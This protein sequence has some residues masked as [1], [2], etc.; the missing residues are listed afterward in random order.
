ML[1]MFVMP[2]ATFTVLRASAG[3]AAASQAGALAIKV[4]AQASAAVSAAAE[5]QQAWPRLVFD[6]L[7]PLLPWL[8]AAW[9]L[10]VLALSLRLL[11][12]WRYVKYLRRHGT[13][14]VSGE[15]QQVLEG[16]LK[17]LRITKPISL[18]ESTVIKIPTV[19]GW[20]RPAIL[21]PTSALTGLSADQIKAII[22]HELAHIRRYDFLINLLQT[23]IE[24][25]LFYHPAVWW[26]SKRV[27]AERENCCDDVAVSVCGDALNYARA[28]TKLEQLRSVQPQLA[29]AATGGSLLGR[30]R[31]LVS[32]P[33]HR[34][35]PMSLW[36]AG[37]L[38][39]TI[40]FAAGAG[41]R[42]V[43]S[44]SSNYQPP[45][46]PQGSAEEQAAEGMKVLLQTLKGRNFEMK[47]EVVAALERIRSSGTIEPMLQALRD[48][49]E[50]T[51]EKVA[52]ALGNLR[53]RRAVEPLAA[54]LTSGDWRGQH[55]VAWA[56]GMIGDRRAVEPLV[57][58]LK[59]G[60]AD[61]RHGSAWALGKI[62]DK[63]AIEP[64][65]ALLKDEAA[66]VRH[67]AAWALGM[68][69]DP[70]AVDA[71]REAQNDKDSDVRE[72][73]NQALMKLSRQ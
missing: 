34:P 59:K 41:L 52:W 45:Q 27:R 65:I 54:A 57:Q 19:I 11:G 18:L 2:V 51:R 3:Q 36:L 42:S 40:I 1:L 66:D 4:T 37:L 26:V 21:L 16:V 17:R 49:D 71:L 8:V 32:E 29:V 7:S 50:S 31:R 30:I 55:T 58:T 73:A 47:G 70:S 20:L 23:V 22:A 63:A 25:L 68:I 38:A 5:N 10:G 62:G 43:L 39:L 28:L 53:D 12:G 33:S 13:R 6:R 72:A 35:N 48:G 64:L 67:G 9:I 14:P 15:Y 56:L 44:S 69:G 61:A 60:N 24:T 46:Y